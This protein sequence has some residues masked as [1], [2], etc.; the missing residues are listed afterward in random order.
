[1]TQKTPTGN[2]LTGFYRGKVLARSKNGKGYLKVFIPGVYPEEF[3]SLENA[4][5][6]PDCEQAA[7][8]FGGCN[9]GNGTFSY[10]NEGSVVWCFF[11]N[12]DPN[13]P[14][15]FASSPGTTKAAGQFAT[16]EQKLPT[17][18]DAVGP[19]G[20]AYVHKITCGN[21]TVMIS[22][23]G[24]VTIKNHCKDTKTNEERIAQIEMD[25]TGC[26]HIYGTKS[27][28]VETEVFKVDASKQMKFSSPY[29]TFDTKRNTARNGSISKSGQN[30]ITLLSDT[31]TMNVPEGYI[32][33]VSLPNGIHCV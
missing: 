13:F 21:S 1:M 20:G 29:I 4:T 8:L 30:G 27:V 7:P 3:N 16:C 25:E 22:E 24:H 26:I 9:N 19:K 12:G 14:V 17:E 18:G 23:L 15:Y 32:T 5:N 31:V 33:A 2:R 11:Q 28:M 6:L 10:P